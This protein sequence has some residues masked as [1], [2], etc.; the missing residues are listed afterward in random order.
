MGRAQDL[1]E[2]AM[3]NMNT[4]LENKEFNERSEIENEIKQL[5]NILI[6]R[7]V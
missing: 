6:Q 7:R 3:G 4:L 2:K 5:D 1:L